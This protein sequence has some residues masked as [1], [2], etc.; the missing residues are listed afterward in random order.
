IRSMQVR[1]APLIGATA[2]FGVALALM[3]DGADDEALA[4][5]LSMLGA[6][7]PT[8]VNLHW[9]LDRMSAKLATLPATERVEAAW[10]EAESIRA[11]DAATCD[12]IGRHGLTLIREL[13]ARRPG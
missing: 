2:A 6:T 9:A 7:R 11:D 12:A 4:H 10:T 5:A 1:G 8:A 13:A 3:N